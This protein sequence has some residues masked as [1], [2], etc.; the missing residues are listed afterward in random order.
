MEGKKGGR[1]LLKAPHISSECSAAQIAISQ[2]DQKHV[3]QG[4]ACQR[5][6]HLSLPNVEERDNSDRNDFRYSMV[7]RNQ[8]YILDT[9]D[10]QHP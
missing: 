7:T 5:K 4:T 2:S 10:N 6:K 3:D 9:I 8:A 1:G